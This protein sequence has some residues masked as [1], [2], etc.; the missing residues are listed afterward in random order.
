MKVVMKMDKVHENLRKKNN[1]FDKLLTKENS[2]VM[3]DIVV[4]LRVSNIKDGQIEEIR[5]D[6]LEMAIN[7]QNRG[8]PITS[9]IPTDYKAFCDDIIKNAQPKTLREKVFENAAIFARG[10]AIMLGINIV[11][12]KF[13]A[14][15]L[16]RLFKGEPIDLYFPVNAGLL[17]A[18]VT[19]I[20][21]A[22]LIVSYI[23]KKSFKLTEMSVQR[24]KQTKN[25]IYPKK[26]LWGAAFGA[27]F[28]LLVLLTFKLGKY[29]LFSVNIFYLIIAIGVL[30][31]L[32]RV[33]NKFI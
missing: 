8:E 2:A 32:D 1:E 7:A 14:N 16:K 9:V 20:A 28:A 22:Y 31:V 23:G 4:Y 11:L 5:Q 12:S 33:F 3:T 29:V 17:I 27:A 6:L 18:T 25:K 10:L 24:K 30:I 13:T 19:I 26:I 21:A 15:L